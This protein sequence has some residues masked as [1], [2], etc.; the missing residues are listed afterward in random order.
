MAKQRYLVVIVRPP[1]EVAPSSPD[2]RSSLLLPFDPEE[3]VS[4]FVQ[5]LW[6]RLSR[7]GQ[8]IPLTPESHHVALHLEDAS[9]PAID[10]HD[11]LSDVILD[12]NREKIYAVF[13]RKDAAHVSG[14]FPPDTRPSKS[15][16]QSLLLRLRP[17]DP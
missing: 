10:A 6:K 11:T 16:N 15:P 3:P 2:R 17:R 9:G 14:L 1:S 7:H 13:S 5:E 4:A 8:T 12:T